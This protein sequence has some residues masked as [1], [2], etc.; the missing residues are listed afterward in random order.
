M[1]TSPFFA[2]ESMRCRIR[3][4]N[5]RDVKIV[6]PHIGH[7]ARGLFFNSFDQEWFD[8]NVARGYT[9]VQDQH[10]V[11]SRNVLTGL[12]YQIQQPSG[13]LLRV[14]NGEVFAVALDLRRWSVT[15][16]RWVGERI[17]AANSWQ[18]WIPPGFAYGFHVR[19]EVAEILVRT[20]SKRN[21]TFERT[22][23]WNDPEINIAWGVKS[24]PFVAEA[25][26]SCVGFPAIEVF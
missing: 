15:F 9:F 21:E 10:M 13:V 6:E 17:S 19:S 12:H 25:S 8:E 7:D 11:F 24:E 4:T 26:S 23:C 1:S 5:I 3:H 14:V 2:T 18:I 16:G 20:T 22:V